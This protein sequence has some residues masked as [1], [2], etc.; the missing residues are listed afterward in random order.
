MCGRQGFE[1]AATV[2]LIRGRQWQKGNA[3]VRV[4]RRGELKP[5]RKLLAFKPITTS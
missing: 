4:D 3:G 1:A 2:A 5:K